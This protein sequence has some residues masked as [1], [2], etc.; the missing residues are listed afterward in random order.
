VTGVQTC[1]LPISHLCIQL[2]DDLLK[3]LK[4]AAPLNTYTLSCAECYYIN[5]NL[6]HNEAYNLKKKGLILSSGGGV[7]LLLI[8]F[9]TKND[10]VYE[11]NDFKSQKFVMGITCPSLI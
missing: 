10:K 9:L 7:L 6:K 5:I 3:R 11:V 4:C 8:T 1:A 2:D